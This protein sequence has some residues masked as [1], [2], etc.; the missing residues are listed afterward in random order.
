MWDSWGIIVLGVE[1]QIQRVNMDH[2]VVAGNK[3]V[4]THVHTNTHT[5]THMLF[6]RLNEGVTKGKR[7]N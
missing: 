6:H 7:V 4:L 2:P 1:Q 3:E 5:Y